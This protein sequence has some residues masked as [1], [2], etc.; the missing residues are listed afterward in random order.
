MSGKVDCRGTVQ[1]VL[2]QCASDDVRENVAT[3]STRYALSEP[4]KTFL[5]KNLKDEKRMSP[6]V[7]FR[8]ACILSCFGCFDIVVDSEDRAQRLASIIENTVTDM[9][10]TIAWLIAACT[11]ST[12]LLPNPAHRI[13]REDLFQKIGAMHTPS[14]T[15]TL[16]FTSATE[17]LKHIATLGTQ[18]VPVISKIDDGVPHPHYMIFVIGIASYIEC[19]VSSFLKGVHSSRIVI[20]PESSFVVQTIFKEGEHPCL[21]VPEED[22]RGHEQISLNSVLITH[23]FASYHGTKN[24][25]NM[26]TCVTEMKHHIKK[27][28]YKQLSKK[29][30]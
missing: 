8:M 23:C 29:Q 28:E 4:T 1:F 5:Y 30:K 15:L 18:D 20:P 13:A 26:I 7:V 2:E 16:A 21:H 25:H 6:A 3:L 22:E 11:D 10:S 9:N 17:Y 12:A 19:A 27:M 14:A 24:L